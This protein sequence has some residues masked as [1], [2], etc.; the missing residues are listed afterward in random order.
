MP[1][2]TFT[3]GEILTGPGLE[4]GFEDEI[5]KDGSED[6]Q[7]IQVT[8]TMIAGAGTW[9]GN[10]V[11]FHLHHTNAGTNFVPMYLEYSPPAD[12]GASGYTG[13]SQVVAVG[14]ISQNP[15]NS[16]SRFNTEFG[17]VQLTVQSTS[18][19]ASIGHSAIGTHVTKLL[20]VNATGTA[21]SMGSTD[22]LPACW[23]LYGTAVDQ[24]NLPTSKSGPLACQEFDMQVNA[25]DDK[26]CRGGYAFNADTKLSVSASG[27]PATVAQGFYSY[28]LGD[29]WIWTAHRTGGNHIM[30]AHDCRPINGPETTVSATSTGTVVSVANVTPYMMG[31][32]D[33]GTGLNLVTNG[34]TAANPIYNVE[35]G[36]NTYQV[37]NATQDGG[38][39]RSG[40]LYL[41]SPLASGDGTVGNTVARPFYALIMRTGDRIAFDYNGNV[42]MYYDSAAV[43]NA[44]GIH[45]KASLQ[46]DQNV[47]VQGNLTVEG[48]AVFN[49]Q[50]DL[51][52]T[53]PVTCS[54]GI[55]VTGGLVGFPIFYG[56]GV[57]L[58]TGQQALP[59]P[60]V[61]APNQ[62]VFIAN[63]CK[64]GETTG[65]GT[66][67]YAF[68]NNN[69]NAWL[70]EGDYT[71]V[72]Y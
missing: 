63:A 27:I 18:N 70:R 53:A 68:V 35:I 72:T 19:T 30:S 28:G 61:A 36:S 51:L 29:T 31:S 13:F 34:T 57:S 23:A 33:T 50:V 43:F 37:N 24:S 46:I 42:Q 41:S 6:A 62:K 71:T 20:P 40:N 14:T 38:G 1:Q 2:P 32:N 48:L 15:D 65:S 4:A 12:R 3:D 11:A 8:G 60:G 16:G 25:I 55:N 54:A 17:S 69:R 47:L 9:A 56:N 59:N 58:S 21:Y 7:A 45:A 10:Q 26:G 39:L 52:T 64:P 22:T 44:G 49:G 5:P 66:G 67:V